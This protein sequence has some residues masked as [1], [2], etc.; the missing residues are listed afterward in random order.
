MRTADSVESA[1]KPAREFRFAGQT[2]SAANSN[3]WR[4]VNR[5]WKSGAPVWRNMQTGDFSAKAMKGWREIR[6]PRV[7]LYKGPSG[8]M[9]EG[10]TRW[11]LEQFGFEYTSVENA[12]LQA[13][14]LRAK[15]DAIVFPDQSSSRERGI[16]EKSVAAIKAFANAGG[17][18][19]YLNHSSDAAL[20][21]LGL[22]AR[23]VLKGV[24]TKDFYSPGSLLN[25]S[26]DT[27]HPLAL[28]MPKEFTIWSE[29]SPA[30]QAEDSQTVVRYPESKLLASRWL[31][32]ENYLA[33]R[34]AVTD[35]PV[36][37][38]RAIL[39]GMRPQYR[40]QSYLTLKLLFK[41]LVY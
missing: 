4:E 11:I 27:N 7:G 18:L 10:W 41:A 22:K 13:G 19:I 12:A 36:G 16:D 2:L 38:G 9:D 3:A 34:A 29:G 14:D 35:V 26:V 17:K 6:R 32:G 20:E 30:W 21:Q 39:F 23:N 15:F 25:V 5:I 33:K 24:S 28:G 40:A 37:Q 1:L 31:L 8:N